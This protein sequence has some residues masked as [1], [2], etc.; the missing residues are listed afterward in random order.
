MVTLE[1]LEQLASNPLCGLGVNRNMVEYSFEIF[2]R[3]IKKGSI[4]EL[5][6]AEGIMTDLIY[7]LGYP[8]TLVDG[9]ALFCD[10]LRKRYPDT[11]VYHSLFEDY[12]TDKKF[13]TIILGHVLEHVN[14]PVLVLRHIK[15][16]LSEDGIILAAVPN[17][18]SIHRQAAVLMGLI[19][20]IKT[21]SELDK[22]VGHMRVYTIEEFK[23][24]F[25][26][27]GLHVEK[28]GGYWLKPL[29][30]SQIEKSWTAEMI[31]AFMKLGE[32]YPDIAAEIYV[33][34]GL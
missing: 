25:I 21:F 4:L 17:A 8:L 5:G 27:A 13:Q 29:T 18:N 28:L 10:E 11:E 2:K 24:D 7:T 30:N 23:S 33:V 1:S 19:P 26:S 16:F 15:Q 14:D 12:C 9:S 31:E 22:R 32:Q 3:H 34:A 6:P 20:D